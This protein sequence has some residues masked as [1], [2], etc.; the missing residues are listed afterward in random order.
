[1]PWI[2]HSDP[3]VP[4]EIAAEC[5][6]FFPGMGGY[7]RVCGCTLYYPADILAG[8]DEECRDLWPARVARYINLNK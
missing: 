5:G 3:A 8:E 2:T 1:M 6:T 4:R 7:C